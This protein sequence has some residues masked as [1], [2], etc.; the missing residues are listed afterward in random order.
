MIPLPHR[1]PK[2]LPRSD[3]FQITASGESLDVLHHTAAHH[4]S[5][6]CDGPVSVEITFAQPVKSV[7]VRPLRHGITVEITDRKARFEIPG[8]TLLQVEVAGLPLLYLYALPP[9]PEAPTGSHVKRFEAGRI[10]EA[11]MITLND[12]EICWIEPGAVVSGAIRAQGCSGVRV[13]GYGIFE[14]SFWPRHE[15]RRLKS[16]VFE[17]CRDCSVENLL[18]LGPTSWMVVLANC[19]NAE[20]RGVRQIADDVSSDGIDIVGSREVR[21]SGCMLHNGDDNIAIKALNDNPGQNHENWNNPVEDVVV[22]SCAFYNIHGGSAMEIGYETSTESIRNVR[23][24]DIDVL[25]VHNFGSVF[26][27]H[28]GDR[29]LVENITWENIRV[30]HHYDKLVDFRLVWSRW[31][32]DAERGHARNL[33]L[34]N[35]TVAQI[36]PNVGYTLSVIAGYDADHAIENVRFENFVLGGRRVQNADQLDLV[37][38]HAHGVRFE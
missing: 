15:G 18:M 24:E 29:A 32:R 1:Y 7:L 19:E 2:E 13:G 16:I 11:G 10:H 28:S 6:E 27:I 12:G 9:A 8:P 36:A 38:R 31:N 3:V 14:G 33:L 37:T 30:E 21:I 26:G 35:I 25:A 20:V 22:S 4:A 23:F 17:N 5:F 34:R